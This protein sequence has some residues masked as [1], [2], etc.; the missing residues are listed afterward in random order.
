[1]DLANYKN[2]YLTFALSIQQTRVV[3]M[4]AGGALESFPKNLPRAHK[5]YVVDASAKMSEKLKPVMKGVSGSS[6]EMEFDLDDGNP[7]L[8]PLVGILFTH[9]AGLGGSPNVDYGG[10]LKAQEVVMLFAHLEAFLADS[11]RVI[12]LKEPRVLKKNKK[13]QWDTILECGSWEGVID[14]MVDEYVFEAGWGS[15]KDKIRNMR[16]AYGLE[17]GVSD[18]VLNAL[19]AAEQLRNVLV[20]NGGR[21]SREYLERTGR[22]D[23]RV[24]DMV[25]LDGSYIEKLSATVTVLGG[26]VFSAIAVKFFGARPDE[27][28]LVFKGAGTVLE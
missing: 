24:G 14:K 10:L 26:D 21:V 13:M 17:I 4:A 16:S 12:C 22:N 27:L 9:V 20:H 3:S 2:A 18:T 15:I 28:R 5:D 7:Y 25:P 19:D 6:F 11:I 8:L 23:V 1:M